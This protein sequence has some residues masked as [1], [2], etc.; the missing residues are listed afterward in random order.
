M[1]AVDFTSPLG[2][3]IDSNVEVRTRSQSICKV[4]QVKLGKN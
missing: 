1:A 2:E 3:T 4:L